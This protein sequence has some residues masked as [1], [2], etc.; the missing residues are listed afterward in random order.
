MRLHGNIVARQYAFSGH[1]MLQTPVFD[2]AHRFKPR[3]ADLGE[4]ETMFTDHGGTICVRVKPGS[5]VGFTFGLTARPGGAWRILGMAC[6]VGDFKRPAGAKAA[7]ISSTVNVAAG[8]PG[9]VV[10]ATGTGGAP[11]ADLV[12][13]GGRRIGGP[14][15]GAVT[16]MSSALAFRD[17]T[18]RTTTWIVDHPAAG[19]WRVEPRAGSAPIASVASADGLPSPTVS[20]K[21]TG[22]GAKRTVVWKSKLRGNQRVRLYEVAGSRQVLLA[23][24]ARPRGQLT[25]RPSAGGPSRRRILAVIEQDGIPRTE[26]SIARFRAKRA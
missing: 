25:F 9:L 12:G 4:A 18:T 1:A 15:L 16:K 26:L 2:P 24:R 3:L 8:L 14:D 20:A 22:H 19:A 6:D 13:P 17:D 11:T 23:T 21:V 7:A 10:V 5:P